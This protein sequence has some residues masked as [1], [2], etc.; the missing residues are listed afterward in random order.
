MSHRRLR[1]HA[2]DADGRARTYP[3]DFR[4]KPAFAAIRDTIV[5]SPELVGEGATRRCFNGLDDDGDGRIDLAD[6]GCS[7]QNDEEEG[8]DPPRRVVIAH[9]ASSA[10][11]VDGDLS[12]WTGFLALELETDWFAS[13]IGVAGTGPTAAGDLGVGVGARWSGTTLYLAFDVTDDVHVDGDTDATL[14]Q[15]DSLQIAFDVGG[16]GG[17]GYDA[18]DHEWG[19][20]V[21]AGRSVVTSFAGTGEPTAVTVVAGRRTRY[22]I[23]IPAALLGGTL[24]SGTRLRFSFLLN[25]DDSATTPD[26]TGR[27]GWLELTGGIGTRKRPELFGEIAISAAPAPLRDASSG[28]DGGGSTAGPATPGCACSV[29]G[30]CEARDGGAAASAGLSALVLVLMGPLARRWRSRARSAALTVGEP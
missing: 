12:E 21:V 19:I 24:T 13:A 26:G 22:E 6:R 4:D 14:W 16:D 29:P 28:S 18:D 7:S 10:P 5:A 15:A 30:T 11:T 1:R 25:E 27:E 17:D 9:A 3:A 20:G 8:F 2:T 23:A